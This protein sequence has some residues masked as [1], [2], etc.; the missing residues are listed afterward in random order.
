M[1]SVPIAFSEFN[2]LLGELVRAETRLNERLETLLVN[3]YKVKGKVSGVKK[4]SS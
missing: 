1:P 2:R 4:R 3:G